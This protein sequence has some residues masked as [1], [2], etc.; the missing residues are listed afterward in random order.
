MASLGKALE[1]AARAHEGQRDKEGLPYIQHPLRV[2]GRVSGEDAQIVAILHDVV[3]DTAVTI[4]DLR[5]AGFSDGILTAV[6]LVTHERSVPYADYVVACKANATARAVKLGDLA[7]NCRLDRMILRPARV[8]H[9][10]A[11]IHRYFLS[12]K[13]LTD[14]ISEADYR[15]LMSQHGS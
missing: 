4:D 8:Q 12:Y 6:Q 15:S 1:I 10:F 14:Q 2:M 3:E 11:R 9:D 13:F 7:D 5:A